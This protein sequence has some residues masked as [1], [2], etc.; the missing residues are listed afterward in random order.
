MD[1]R[2]MDFLIEAGWCTFFALIGLPD[3][4]ALPILMV[5]GLI[6]GFLL[7]RKGL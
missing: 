1:E 6:T 3:Y 4:L 2:V 7:G 5:G